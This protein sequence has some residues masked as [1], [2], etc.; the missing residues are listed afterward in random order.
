[1]QD[2]HTLT[3]ERETV[4]KLHESGMTVRQ[5]ARRLDLSTQ[6][7][8]QQLEKLRRDGHLRAVS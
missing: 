8:Y 6:R 5:I 1:V 3:Q 2:T 7:I 4:L